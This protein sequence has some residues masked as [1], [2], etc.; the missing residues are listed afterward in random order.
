M[1]KFFSSLLDIFVKNQ[2]REL[3]RASPS[4]PLILSRTR[5]KYLSGRQCIW[6]NTSWVQT[7]CWKKFQ[8][9]LWWW[10]VEMRKGGTKSICAQ[11][12]VPS[13]VYSYTGTTGKDKWCLGE[14]EF[15]PNWINFADLTCWPRR[16]SL[17]PLSQPLCLR[18]QLLCFSS[19]RCCCC[20]RPSWT[21]GSSSTGWTGV[22]SWSTEGGVSGHPGVKT[23][24][25]CFALIF[26]FAFG[27]L[28]ALRT[29]Y[30][31]CAMM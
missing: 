20:C 1:N 29:W 21:I 7:M 26:A 23:L 27:F 16:G 3:A 2:V 25:P 10:I 6:C 13:T 22:A 18:L 4:L 11:C 28:E 19:S 9:Y 30:F 31:F 12:T 8:L 5:L 24:A 15:C 14:Q 17:C